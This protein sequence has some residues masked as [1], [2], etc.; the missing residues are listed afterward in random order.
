MMKFG[1][2]NFYSPTG[3]QGNYK[4][5]VIATDKSGKVQ[6]AEI[7]PPFPDGATGYHMICIESPQ[8]TIHAKL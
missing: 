3:A 7:R 6:T 8:R 5:V 2:M 1:R 4:L